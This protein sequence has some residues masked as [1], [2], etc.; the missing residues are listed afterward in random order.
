MDGLLVIDK[1]AGPTSHD[2]VARMRRVLGER[3]I[4]HT[5][6]LDPS[7]TGLLALVIGRATRLARFLSAGDKSY[8]A[9]V[10]LGVATDSYDAAG[11]VIGD[12]Y[13]GPLPSRD[14]IEAALDAFRGTFLQQPPAFSAKK[15]GGKRSHF[16]A[17][18]TP[19]ALP[20]QPALP[21]PVRVTVHRLD[22]IAVAGDL[23]TLRVDCSAGFYV[24]SLAHD[25]GAHLGT[26]AHLA[27]LR[28]TR[29]GDLK[30]ADAL[31]LAAAEAGADVAR[32]AVIPLERMLPGLEEVVL[33]DT[34][35][36]HAAHGKALG[37][38]DVARGTVDAAAPC[39]LVD[40]RGH[41]V[42]IAEPVGRP[43]LLH[44]S[45]ILV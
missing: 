10:R 29:S 19:P 24:R 26:G 13:S 42:G 14:A 2:V 35:A 37:S 3:R 32:R 9:V 16:L 18:A 39:R 8:D 25:L 43:G 11:A 22:V 5:G 12:A 28:R 44:P 38:A 41:L 4:G 33:T 6:T 40:A 23:V 21:A 30:L 15:I 7:A 34:G 45:V 20:A 27:S 31:P 36:R 1:P 17:R